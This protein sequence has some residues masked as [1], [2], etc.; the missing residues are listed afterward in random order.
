[1]PAVPAADGTGLSVAYLLGTSAGGTGAHVALLASGCAARGAAVTVYG[2]AA[3]GQRF[4]GRNHHDREDFSPGSAEKSSRSWNSSA[5]ARVRFV[6][7]EIGDR[8]RPVRDL[9]A[10]L[11]LRR[12]LGAPSSGAAQ[13][14][15]AAHQPGAAP[16]SGMVPAPGAVS[17]PGVVHAHGLR[18]GAAGA[19]ALAL[20]PPGRR[21][22]LLVTVHNAPPD[23][24]L[25]R[26][27]HGGL[28]RLAARRAAV[29]TCVSSDL[30][31]RMRRLGA[32]DAGRALV[33]APV[34]PA[35]P[36]PAVA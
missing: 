25:A 1:M 34:R 26:L 32:R 13:A 10:V 3:T 7:V 20:L 18:A 31:D 36:A 17:E 16:A 29:V 2:P 24:R 14:P 11:R 19:L 23:G 15:E 8:P 6:P 33:P 5:G 35:P 30:T 4:F 9:M 21:P 22:A 27:L 12:L 28:E